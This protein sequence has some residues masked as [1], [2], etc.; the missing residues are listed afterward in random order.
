MPVYEFYCA[1]C[2]TVFNFLSRLVN[3]DKR[4]A[5]PKCNRPE[6]ERQVSPF[7]VSR[8]RKEETPEGLP[9]IDE[10]KLEKAMMGLAGEIEGMD[11]NNPRQMAHFLRRLKDVTGMNLGSGMDKAIRRLESGDDPDKIESEMGEL[12]DGDNP[13]SLEGIKGIRRRVTPP[14]H[15]DTLYPL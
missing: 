15:D 12:L 6:L 7:A 2:H 10:Q 8:G 9:D 3:I 14:V 13:F 4:P 5:C 11:E 1:D